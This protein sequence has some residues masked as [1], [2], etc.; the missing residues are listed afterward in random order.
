MD[1]ERAPLPVEGVL[2]FYNF[3]PLDASPFLA[4]V[5]SGLARPQ[6][7][8]PPKYF[9]DEHGSRL[10]EQIC[11]LPEY[12]LTRTELGIIQ[13]NLAE[14]AQFIGPDVQLIELGSGSGIKTR[15]L[16][17][18]LLPPLYVPIDI[19]GGTMRSASNQ[20]AELFPWLNVVGLC[21]DYT[22]PLQ[23]PQF[24]GVPIRRKAVF[25]PGSTVGNF[26]PEEA[27]GFLR[28]VRRMAGAGG[29]LLIGVDLKK[30]KATLDAA[31]DDAA[32]VTAKFNLNLLERINR[33]LG[34]DFKIERFR[35]K[36][37][38][39][40]I[41]GWIEMHIESGYA[42]IVHVGAKR[43]DFAVGETI[44]TEISCKYSIGEFQDLAKKAGFSPQKVW[45]DPQQ[46][47]SVHGM[48]A[49]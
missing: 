44:H 23:L 17:E 46:L 6:K 15:L 5:L 21:A 14:I 31:Y 40:P 7:S 2:R 20:L 43:F 37:F 16:I 25:F 13:A 48:I 42:Q 3:L 35:H 11:A 45:T 41:R 18:R 27:L 36:A 12:Y 39:D 38:Y 22:A 9:Y 47:F 24:A 19:D 26:T 29:A 8:I 32:G 30:D 49:V 34:G 1:A 10:F 33:E 28:Q 4:T